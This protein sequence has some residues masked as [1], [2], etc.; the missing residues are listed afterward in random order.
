[1]KPGDVVLAYCRF[2]DPP[3]NKYVACVCIE[4]NLFLFI[5]S[6]PRRLTTEALVPVR[7]NELPFLKHDSYINTANL[8]HI[9]KKDLETAKPLGELTDDIK[10][11]II[12]NIEGHGHLPPL[13]INLIIENFTPHEHGPNGFAGTGE[14]EVK[15]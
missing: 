8:F 7:P 12:K 9:G 10:Q 13:H 2:I 5:N 11:A 3:K 6:Q 14:A 15:T 1:M 4:N